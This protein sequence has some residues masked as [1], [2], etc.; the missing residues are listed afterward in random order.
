M[1]TEMAHF[2]KPSRATQAGCDPA[3]ATLE[4]IRRQFPA[5]ARKHLGFDVAYF[6]GPGG[7]QVPQC[8]VDAVVE[9]LC[10]HNANSHWNFPTSAETDAILD[11]A[12]QAVADFVGG[13]PSEVV[14]GANA[15]TLAFHVSR[16]LGQ[17]LSDRDEIV[18][19]ELDHHANVAPWQALARERGCRLRTAK[20]DTEQGTLDWDD[21]DRQFS[22]RTKLVAIGAASNALG[23]VT[24][25]ARACRLAKEVGA[26]AFVD[27]VHYAP[28]FVPAV[29]EWGCDFLVCSAYKF[30]GPHVGALWC[31]S[32]L[33]ESLPFAKLAPAPNHG[34]DRAETGTKNHEGI[35]GAAAAV[36]FL[37]SLA[38]G[39]GAA[40]RRER[41][42]PALGGV[43]ER[44]SVF[45]R[46][47]WDGLSAIDGITLYGPPP[48]APRTS[49]IAFAVRG[50]PSSQVAGQLA[51]RGMFLSHGNF[52]AAAT[53]ERLGLE[54]EG[55]VRA[56]CACY[57]T[58]DEVTRLVDG[59]AAVS[60]GL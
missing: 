36:D 38:T 45:V 59:V 15:T 9:Y 4:Q 24:D 34:P 46:Q 37:A 39:G 43:H 32:E 33:L 44:T 49:T 25:V 29:N 22:S 1:M 7:T 3:V 55:L 21:F 60:R 8:V 41:L 31:R 53:V 58:A 57:T 56:G 23:T 27:A 2:T 14:F 50:V 18:V 48:D 13:K 12:R 51:K 42:N 35:A 54:A 40:S 28:H 17:L 20:M 26:L 5:L 30:Y 10:H 47:I 16:A 52:Y 19:T 6:D 11:G